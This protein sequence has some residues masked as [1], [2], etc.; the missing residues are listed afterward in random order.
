MAMGQTRKFIQNQ[1][2]AAGAEMAL[3]VPL[4]VTIMFGS[5]ELG[6]YYWNE[7]A[8]IKGVRDGARYAARQSFTK[9]NCGQAAILLG[10]GSTTTD[11]A[12]VDQVKN[13]VRTGDVAGTGTPKVRGWE[14]SHVS[15]TVSCPATALTTGIY[16]NM[17]NAPR[18]TVSTT[19]PY[20]SLFGSIGLDVTTIN[21]SAESQSAVMG[22]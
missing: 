11:T 10:D 1:N 17:A 8:V 7:H 4:L 5:F 14:N 3:L 12:F 18:V 22:L 15:V 20:P 6:L 9:F 21:L 13:L 16:K 19:V 2:G